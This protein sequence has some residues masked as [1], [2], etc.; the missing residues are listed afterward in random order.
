MKPE[1]QRII[2]NLKRD[3]EQ[4]QKSYVK[5]QGDYEKLRACVLGMKRLAEKQAEL[6][7]PTWK[8]AAILAGEILEETK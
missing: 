5:I 2:A 4:I 1:D 6:G 8:K 3:Y 7:S